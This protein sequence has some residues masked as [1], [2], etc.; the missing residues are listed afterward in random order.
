M[1]E[2]S[3]GAAT[4]FRGAEP[5]GKAPRRRPENNQRVSAGGEIRRCARALAGPLFPSRGHR[6][7]LFM[8]SRILLSLLYSRRTWK[9]S[10][11]RGVYFPG[12]RICLPR[13][14]RHLRR[15]ASP[16]PREKSNGGRPVGSLCRG[17]C[18]SPPAQVFI[19]EKQFGGETLRF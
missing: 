10:R 11:R 15:Q 7:G 19:Q 13:G 17:D 3:S 2:G 14:R 8:A 1:A 12:S 16:S 18:V 4:E 5:G 6:Q 9:L